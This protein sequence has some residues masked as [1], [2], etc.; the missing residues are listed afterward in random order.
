MINAEIDVLAIQYIFMMN[1]GGLSQY[2]HLKY[3]FFLQR[4]IYYS[5]TLLLRSLLL[6]SY[7]YVPVIQ[8]RIPHGIPKS[9]YDDDFY[10]TCSNDLPGYIKFFA[11]PSKDTSGCSVI[12]IP[13]YRYGSRIRDRIWY[14]G[15]SKRSKKSDSTRRET[16]DRV[17]ESVVVTLVAVSFSVFF[18]SLVCRLVP[19]ILT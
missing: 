13:V 1:L 8:K 15:L 17:S 11:S 10:W 9:N 7:R 14:P 3:D 5:F 6:G 18:Q 16:L 19:T 12:L 2:F 4:S